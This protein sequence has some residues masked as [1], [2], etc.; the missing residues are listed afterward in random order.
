MQKI[1]SILFLSVL[2]LWKGSELSAQLPQA[3]YM[4][5]HFDKS[6]YIAG[7]DVWFSLHFLSPENQKSEVVYAELF[8]P[9]GEQLIRHTLKV[10]NEQVSGDFI[11]PANLAE[12]YYTFRAYTRWNLNYDPPVM[13]EAQIPVYN[14]VR[15]ISALPKLEEGSYYI[16]GRS[17]GFI[18][19]LVNSLSF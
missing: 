7:E 15:G 16:P 18:R 6:F 17:K 1:Y 11:L 13:L 14:A 19:S 10:E 9:E 3:E 2:L 12:G 5:I 8:S 4:K